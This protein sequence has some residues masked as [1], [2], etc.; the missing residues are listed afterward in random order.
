MKCRHDTHNER[1]PIGC[2]RQREEKN[3][4]M[5]DPAPSEVSPLVNVVERLA[6]PKLAQPEQIAPRVI[7]QVRVLAI[8]SAVACVATPFVLPAFV[9]DIPL[10]LLPLPVLALTTLLTGIQAALFFIPA[11]RYARAFCIISGAWCLC[12]GV[13]AFNQVSLR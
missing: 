6:L 4:H 1:T 9:I 13:C 10:H 3:T 8:T 5:S 2:L 11:F 12:V 7:N